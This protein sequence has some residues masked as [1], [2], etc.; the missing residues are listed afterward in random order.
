[1]VNAFSST[2]PVKTILVTGSEGNIGH[3]LVAALRRRYPSW[4]VLRVARKSDQ[5]SIFDE[6]TLRYVGNLAEPTFIEEIL[7]NE[8]IDVLVHAASTSYGHDGYLTNPFRVL[9]ND[10]RLTLNLMRHAASFGKIIYLS[11][12]LAYERADSLELIEELTD[13]IPAPTSSYGVAK[14]VGEQAVLLAH[15]QT[16]VPYTI[17]RPFNVVSPL[18]PT[19]G[20]GRHVFVDFYR[21]LFIERVDQFRVL[22]SG[23]QVRCFIWV[24]EAA[25]C[26]A[27]NIE[28]LST[29]NEVI[30]LARRE[31]LS[32]IELK[33][34]LIELGREVGM[35]PQG[36]N[37]SIVTSGQFAGVEMAKRIPSTEKLER[38]TGWRSKISVRECM[39]RFIRD[40]LH[41]P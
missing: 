10:C 29:D 41:K 25:E 2:R 12:A 39:A 11:S 30:N 40:K 6:K 23:Q 21:R 13:R 31:P 27:Q 20:D 38:L 26:I 18:E 36:Y 17:W 33:D 24:E 37:P 5:K 14:Y 7:Q 9:E 32:L 35:I 16:G 34:L 22:G 15:Q 8:S 1:M 28:M 4:R 19:E 3:Y